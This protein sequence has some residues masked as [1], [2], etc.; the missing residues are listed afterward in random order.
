MHLG[1]GL[2]WWEIP[3][4]NIISGGF[5]NIILGG[6]WIGGFGSII[7][8]ASRTSIGLVGGGKFGSML[9]LTAEFF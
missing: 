8:G 9:Y 5:R 1:H 4:G 3:T 2:D 6:A 7:L